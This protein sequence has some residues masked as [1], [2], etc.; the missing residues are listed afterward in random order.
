LCGTW[1]ITPSEKEKKII[2]KDL[3][4]VGIWTQVSALAASC[5]VLVS[6]YRLGKKRRKE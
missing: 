4:G 1:P 2:I 3:S 6:I 5:P